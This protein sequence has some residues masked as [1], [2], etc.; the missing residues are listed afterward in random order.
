DQ[1]V[2]NGS[3]TANVIFSTV[4]TG[5]TTSYSWSNNT[6][7]IG[8]AASGTGNIPFFTAVNSGTDP[9]IATITVTP[10]YTNNFVS[11]TGPS[12]T[13]TITVNP[14]ANVVDPSDQVVCNT[15]NTTAV[16]F[17][18]T[19]GGG[20]SM[21]YNWTNSKPGIGLAASGTGDIADFTAENTG[22]SPVVAIITVTPGLTFDGKTC[23][24]PAQTFT[25]TVNP[26]AQ[27]ND[28]ADQVVCKGAMTAGV[29]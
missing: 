14:V 26:T 8:L 9:V 22:N 1:V 28:P 19:N 25:I 27:V 24:G 23:T 13:F 7:A 21:V 17:T 10:E 11:C 6:P 5:G 2:C 20:V 12:K 15:D 18:T 29:L 4:N 16:T 3:S